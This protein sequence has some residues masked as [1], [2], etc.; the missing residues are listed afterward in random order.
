MGRDDV[1]RFIIENYPSHYDGFVDIRPLG[2]QLDGALT[3]RHASCGF[4][5]PRM[6]IAIRQLDRPARKPVCYQP[7]SLFDAAQGLMRSSGLR[8]R[9]FVGFTDGAIA[10]GDF[11][12]AE[13][14][15]NTAMFFLKILRRP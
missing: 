12:T 10:T 6:F 11:A 1:I 4:A 3:K 14:E 8:C 15:R 5:V 7:R 9:L 2:Y 13:V